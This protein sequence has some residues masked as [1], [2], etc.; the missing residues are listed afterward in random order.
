MATNSKA[1]QSQFERPGQMIQAGDVDIA[2]PA[3][4]AHVEEEAD[5]DQGPDHVHAGQVGTTDAV[6]VIA[7][8]E[9]AVAATAEN[10][11]EEEAREVD[12]DQDR[13]QQA[14]AS[15]ETR[16]ENENPKTR[17]TRKNTATANKAKARKKRNT[18]TVNMKNVTNQVRE[19]ITR[20]TIWKV[21]VKQATKNTQ[22]KMV[23]PRMA[24]HK[25]SLVSQ[26]LLPLLLHLQILIL[27]TMI[28]NQNQSQRSLPRRVHPNQRKS[29][30]QREEKLTEKTQ[31]PTNT[32]FF[33]GRFSAEGVSGF[34]QI[35]IFFSRDSNTKTETERP[36]LFFFFV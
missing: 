17:T 31:I 2:D 18:A 15:P 36:T 1:N 32:P 12:Q 21:M 11:E 7:A 28:Q 16:A 35:G 10:E 5:Q 9:A 27:I 22:S 20:T 19:K 23:M 8:P 30:L 24:T 29:L 14:A 6:V 4:E 34:K 26:Y 3:A 25:R 13:D 33:V